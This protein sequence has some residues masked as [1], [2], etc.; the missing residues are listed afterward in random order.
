MPIRTVRS[1]AAVLENQQK[2]ALERG[3]FVYAFEEID[4]KENFDHLIVD[5]LHSFDTIRDT[6]LGEST[7]FVKQ[8][9]FI[10][11]PYFMWSNRGIGKMKVWVPEKI[12]LK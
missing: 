7:V 9:N 2:V 5:P 10:A 6:I 8:N 3:P 4:N 12:P 1:K 11:L